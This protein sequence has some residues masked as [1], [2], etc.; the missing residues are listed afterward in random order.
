MAYNE[1]DDE[2]SI[3][4]EISELEREIA[5]LDERLYLLFTR[6]RLINHRIADLQ[7]ILK[8]KHA[9]EQKGQ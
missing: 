2:T 8:C 6:K 3:L 7:Y 4:S 1:S 5:D 9:E